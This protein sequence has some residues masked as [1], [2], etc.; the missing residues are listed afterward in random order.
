MKFPLSSWKPREKRA[1]RL[2]GLP[3][4]NSTRA[5]RLAPKNFTKLRRRR[6]SKYRYGSPWEGARRSCSDTELVQEGILS[7]QNHCGV[8]CPH[9]H[10]PRAPLFIFRPTVGSRKESCSSRRRRP[11]SSPAPW[12]RGAPASRPWSSACAGWRRWEAKPRGLA[13]GGKSI[14]E[15]FVA[16]W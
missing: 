14:F 10:T 11:R 6:S 13:S 4:K 9:T 15:G 5:T 8:L 1:C 7:P 3:P 16:F 2:S 12:R